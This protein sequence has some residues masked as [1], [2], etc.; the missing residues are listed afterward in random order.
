V[1]YEFKNQEVQDNQQKEQVVN[2]LPPV[3]KQPA[4]KQIDFLPAPLRRVV[5]S[6]VTRLSDAHPEAPLRNSLGDATA[7]KQVIQLGWLPAVTLISALGLLIVDYAYSVSRLNSLITLKSISVVESLFVLGILLMFVPVVVRLLSPQASRFERICLLCVAGLSL[8]LVQITN[9]PLHFADFDEFLHWRTAEDIAQTGH[10]FQM[11]TLLPV[12]P[13]YPGLQIVTNALSSLS[14]LHIFY[15]GV[16]VLGVARLLILLSL[17]LL[18]EQVTPSARVA[19]IATAIYM[20]N[21]HFIGFDVQYS[22]ESL[23][24]PIAAFMLFILSRLD[25]IPYKQRV[26]TLL[27]WLV[28]A[29]LAFTHHVTNYVFD[30]FLLLWSITY[31]F[32]RPTGKHRWALVFTAFFGIIMAITVAFIPGS[33][34]ISYLSSYFG[35]SLADL[36]RVFVG[37][38]EARPLF[39]NNT[40]LLTPFWDR[41][42]I[43]ASVGIITLTLPF[44]L[45]VVWLRHR[46]NGL[47]LM[48]AVVVL[49][50]PLSQLFRFTS[51]GEEIADRSAAFLFLPIAYVMATFV[52]QYWST[53]RLSWRNTAFITCALSVVF[54]G[55]VL[56]QG[57]PGLSFLPGPYL[58]SA[59][60]R[61]IEPQGTQ[62]ALWTYSHLGTNNRVATDRINSLLMSVY[63]R[64]YVITHL[65]DN[66]NVSSLFL[67]PSVGPSDTKLMRTASIRYLIVDLRLSTDTPL[68]GVYFESGEPNAGQYTKPLPLSSLTKFDAVSQLNREFDSGAI[69]IYDVKELTNAS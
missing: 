36:V 65:A 22:Y 40:G 63:G 15:S 68:V 32:Q 52:T 28:L 64:Q 17:F 58:V 35:G 13:Y 48:F 7:Q 60:N 26:M 29:T 16:I 25:T 44:G 18:F 14:G 4:R 50:Y 62:D 10:F 56:L 9:S 8:Y 24:I 67:D 46:F 55:G 45:I 61:S 54:V 11:N 69:V 20:T 43:A 12:S 27:A 38:S 2:A 53:R 3:A 5:T 6:T 1:K 33:P 21:P 42:L 23:S 59:D 51:F 31:L 37:T 66:V 30:A 41:W 39:V 57:G 34:V 47:A 19:S 49:A